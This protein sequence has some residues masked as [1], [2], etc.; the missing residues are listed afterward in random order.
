MLI[1]P[2]HEITKLFIGINICNLSP[3]LFCCVT[4]SEG[5]DNPINVLYF[6]IITKGKCGMN[7]FGT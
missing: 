5:I 2:F 7:N 6:F 1:H 4:A 3:L